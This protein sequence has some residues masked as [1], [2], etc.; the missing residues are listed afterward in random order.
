MGKRTLVAQNLVRGFGVGEL[1]TLALRDVSIE[2]ESGHVTLMMGP[3]G[4]GK[5]TLLAILSGLLQPDSGTVHTLGVDLW[6]LSERQR[7]EFRRKHCGF[8]FQGYNLF[9]AFTAMQQLEVV[10]QWGEGKTLRQSQK[11]AQ[12]TLES[13]NMGKK[14]HLRPMQL[15][16]GEKQRVAVARALV[17]K[18]ELIFADE[19]TAALDWEH[20]QQVVHLL[21]RAAHEQNATVLLVSHDPRLKPLADRV[22]HL[23]DGQL[24]TDHVAAE[25][26]P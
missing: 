25:A 24:V 3:S 26:W 9:P 12:E 17:K 14:A 16:G 10:L 5:S 18:P 11:L 15:S 8:I 23:E 4:S 1:R 19:P 13:L 2:L 21:R 7:E 20:G 22:L 6:K